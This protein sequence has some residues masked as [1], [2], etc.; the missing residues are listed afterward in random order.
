[1]TVG[2]A[3]QKYEFSGAAENSAVGK[4]N[5]IEEAQDSKQMFLKLLVAQI[6]NQNP[7]SPQDPTQFLGQLTQYSM[8]E[9]LIMIR[10]GVT[11][12]ATTGDG[13]TG[14]GTSGGN[15]TQD[16]ADKPAAT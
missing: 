3:P 7:L 6:Q 13:A 1:M 5:T 8:L 15:S 4:A 9:Q 10:Q 11:P 16:G 12:D 14:S 2:G